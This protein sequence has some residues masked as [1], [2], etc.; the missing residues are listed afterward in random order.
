MP[1][2]KTLNF[3]SSLIEKF[4][5]SM[6]F[7]L[8]RGELYL[9]MKEADSA[10]FDFQTVY[11]NDPQNSRAFQGIQKSQQ[12]QKEQS[13]VDYY[14]ILGL[15]KGASISE[16]KTAYKKSVKDW[17]PDKFPE[18]LEKKK[19]AER[20][21]KQINLAFEL[22]SDPEKKLRIDQ[23]FDPEGVEDFSGGEGFDPF[24]ILRHFQGGERQEFHFGGEGQGFHFEFHF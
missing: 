14:A 2:E 6:E 10:L 18:N 12:M 19:E 23:G 22:L 21:M 11:R 24:D 16:V 13:F 9:E 17:H 4:P 20:K 3:L 7:V 1:R 5:N 8:E 15:K